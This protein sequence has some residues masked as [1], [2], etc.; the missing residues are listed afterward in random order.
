MIKLYN[1]AGTAM[2]ALFSSEGLNARAIAKVPLW[3][4]ISI[5][6]AIAWR[7]GMFNSRGTQ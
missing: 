6:M 1:A 4:P 3:M 7:L 5:P 2:V